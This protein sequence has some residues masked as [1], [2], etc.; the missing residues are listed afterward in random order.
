MALG[1][2]SGGVQR[3]VVRQGMA[4]TL[5][6]VTLGLGTAWAVARLLASFLYGVPPH[7]PVTFT[8]VP[9]FLTLVALL[10]RWLSALRAARADPLTALRHE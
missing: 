1:A 9:L 8:V 4:L 6:A 2:Q 7:D 3:L 5:I 10:A